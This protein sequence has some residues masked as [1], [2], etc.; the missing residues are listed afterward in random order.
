MF[1]RSGGIYSRVSISAYLLA[2]IVI[3]NQR[4]ILVGLNR[5]VAQGNA[6]EGRMSAKLEQALQALQDAKAAQDVEFAALKEQN[7][8]VIGTLA[9][10]KDIV[11]GVNDDN[12]ADIVRQVAEALGVSA[13]E[14]KSEKE[15]LDAAEKAA[16]PSPEP[17]EVPPAPEPTPEQ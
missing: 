11:A 4:R 3:R 5:I 7:A 17:E 1:K 15:A 6:S 2:R 13:N 9:E 10:L 8:E 14:I 12:A 16:D